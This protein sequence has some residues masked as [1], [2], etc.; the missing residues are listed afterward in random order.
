M[1]DCACVCV[2]T[3]SGDSFGERA[4]LNEVRRT[5]TVVAHDVTELLV[6]T[7]RDFLNAVSGVSS[8]SFQP[9]TTVRGLKKIMWSNQRLLATCTDIENQFLE[10]EIERAQANTN[11]DP[12][13]LAAHIES[14]HRIGRVADLG[15]TCCLRA[16]RLHWAALV[17]LMRRSAHIQRKAG[18]ITSP[19]ASGRGGSPDK[20]GSDSA[21]GGAVGA[22]AVSKLRDEHVDNLIRRQRRLLKQVLSRITDFASIPDDIGARDLLADDLELMWC[23][24][25][26]Y[27]GCH[28][29]VLAGVEYP[30]SRACGM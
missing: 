21:D 9:H 29:V 13:S 4:L 8:I 28:R 7:K 1:H 16:L 3:D 15:P 5:A 19:N 10:Q 6:V 12:A 18:G 25:C 26:A 11:Q 23:V 24:G 30:C 17:P 14:L 2:C 27:T 22:R 20:R